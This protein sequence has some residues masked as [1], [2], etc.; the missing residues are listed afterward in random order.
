MTLPSKIR[1]GQY[2][3]EQHNAMDMVLWKAV[4]L[5]F[6]EHGKPVPTDNHRALDLYMRMQDRATFS[7]SLASAME[8]LGLQL[9]TK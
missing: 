4:E 5:M 8:A 9:T 1:S 6:A 7:A 3:S 2:A